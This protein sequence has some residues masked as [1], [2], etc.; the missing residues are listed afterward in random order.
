MRVR[1]SEVGLQLHAELVQA[2]LPFLFNLIDG[3]VFLLKLPQEHFKLFS[4]H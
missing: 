2:V 3:A 1:C 4:T